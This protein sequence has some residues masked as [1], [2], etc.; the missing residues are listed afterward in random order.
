[1]IQVKVKMI[2]IFANPFKISVKSIIYFPFIFKINEIY[3][4]INIK[5]LKI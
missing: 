3:K 5:F 1:M 2:N 4:D